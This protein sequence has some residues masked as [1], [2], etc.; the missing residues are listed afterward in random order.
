MGRKEYWLKIRGEYSGYSWDYFM[1]EKSSTT[2]I[3]KRQ[4]Q[5]MKASGMR[6]K[7]VIC[8]N[9][10]EQMAPLKDM[11]W[12]NGVLGEHVAPY[13]PQENGKVERQFPTDLK[14]ANCVRYSQTRSSTQNEIKKGSNTICLH[15]VKHFNQGRHITS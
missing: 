2:A 9:A 6:V 4:L 12:A 5:L 1:S 14:R 7:T 8:D 13:T 15:N 11:C 3:L 10:K